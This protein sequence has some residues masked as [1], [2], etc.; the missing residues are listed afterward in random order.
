MCGAVILLRICS[1]NG[2]RG[3][4]RRLLL[5]PSLPPDVVAAAAP[6]GREVLANF[7]VASGAGL[8][9]CEDDAGKNHIGHRGAQ[10]GFTSL[11][12]TVFEQAWPLSLRSPTTRPTP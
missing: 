4:G 10:H 3:E 8:T 5:H 6:I 1:E 12:A 9:L 2:D 11:V 7:G